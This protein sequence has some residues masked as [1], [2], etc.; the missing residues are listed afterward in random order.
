MRQTIL[1]VGGDAAVR[2]N[3]NQ[4]LRAAGFEILETDSGGGAVRLAFDYQPTLIVLAID[5]SGSD[6][7]AVCK[8]LK[9]DPGTAAIPVL[10]LSKDESH[11]GYLESLKSGAEGYLHEPFE[12]PV[13]VEAVTALIR[14]QS[15]KA[16]T[17]PAERD[18]FPKDRLAALIESIPDEVW[19]ADAQGRFTLANPSALREF[20]MSARTQVGV[21]ELA[22]GLEVFRAD[23]TPRPVE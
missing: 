20:R 12:S 23:G 18:A 22:K 19:F 8:Q 9:V 6:G 7:F 1:S 3:R 4:V 10:H 17:G 15:V 11:R 13:L 21:E 5:P 14:R 2:S 16:T